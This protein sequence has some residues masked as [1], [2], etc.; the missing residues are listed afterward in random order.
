[1]DELEVE[2]GTCL[3][4]SVCVVLFVSPLW[5]L[6]CGLDDSGFESGRIQEI[7]LY[8]EET[9]PAVGPLGGGGRPGREANHSLPCSAEIQ[10]EWSYIY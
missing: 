9:G 2:W 6:D 8:I 4:C 3:C 1:M 7:Y 5:R 10:I